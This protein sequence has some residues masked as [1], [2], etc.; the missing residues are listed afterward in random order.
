MDRD[1][2]SNKAADLDE[3][4]SAVERELRGKPF[5]SLFW[6]SPEGIGIKPLYTAA[7]LES[8]EHLDSLPGMAP[9]MRG[10]RASM[11]AN[12]PWTIRQYAGF[13]TAEESNQFYRDNLAAGQKGLSV[14]FDLATHRGYD[15]DNPM[16]AQ[17]VGMAGVAIDTVEDMKILFNGIPLDEMSVSMTMNGA[18]LPVMASYIVAAEEQGVSQAALSGT[19]QNDILKEFMVR[20]TYIYPPAASMRIVS[21]IIA[22]TAEH[23]P[24]FNSIS[25]SGYHMQEAG[26]NCV[27]ELA[28]TIADGIEYVRAAINAGQPV[29]KFAP[30]LSFFFC[31]GMN[32]F[33]EVAKLRA[34]RILWYEVMQQ[35]G[36]ENPASSMLRTHCQTSGVSLQEQDPYNNV[37]RTTIEAMAAV[38]GGTQSLH[39]NAFDE[40]IAL[41]TPF[42]ARI[43]RNTQS[44]IADESQITRVVDPLG[45]S[46]YVESLTHSMVVEARKLIS[47]IEEAGGMTSALDEGIPMRHIEESAARRQARVERGEDVIIGVNR[48]P[49]EDDVEVEA[50][51]IDNSKVLRNQVLRLR[52]I[53]EKRDEQA[54][55]S[56]LN[57]LTAA[58]GNTDRNLLASAVEA[59]RARATVGEISEA[60]AA[61]WNRHRTAAPIRRGVFSSAYGDDPKFAKVQE[62]I[63]LFTDLEGRVPSIY[64]VKIGQDGHDRGAKAISNAFSD[65][66]FEVT[67]SE[68]FMSPE[69]AAKQ[70]AE[71][72]V[73]VIGVSTLAGAHRTIVPALM[74][75]LRKEGQDEVTV[76]VGGVIPKR[77]YQYLY[78]C[79]VAGIFGPG[80][81]ILDAASSVLKLIPGKNR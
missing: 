55:R 23:M 22:H 80:T 71:L 2:S 12:R 50:L 36:P 72:G 73:H 20:N 70:T 61:C 5:D 6:N 7:D 60:L 35:F 30:R 53:R 39:T 34:A 59:A 24:R 17:D 3:W 41:P 8:V 37:V 10:P 43:A 9:Y 16:V 69:E 4:K 13:S 45:G 29:D 26:A 57:E 32:F 79:G 51:D 15:S 68:L 18:V 48:Y 11:Y 33:M 75:A 19:I 21:D 76:V 38:L 28:F 67:L 1:F 27:Q 62:E 44:I 47:V 46:Y 52:E 77:D 78:D 31:I 64:V 25:I 66:G 49:V 81:N 42:S 65:A 74:E 56:T 54:V 63:R 40:A 58:A 14:A